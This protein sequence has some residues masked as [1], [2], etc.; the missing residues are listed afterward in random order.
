MSVL[1][2]LTSIARAF[3]PHRDGSTRE[4]SVKV[5][6]RIEGTVE[7]ID[8]GQRMIT[9]RKAREKSTQRLFHVAAQCK[10]TQQ[11]QVVRLDNVNLYDHV[12]VVFNKIGNKLEA[13]DIEVVS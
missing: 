10:I 1:K 6:N 7:S 12:W 13:L 2:T 4:R 11:G 9:V 3:I 5:Y 8:A